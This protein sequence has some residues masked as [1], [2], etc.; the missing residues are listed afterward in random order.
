MATKQYAIAFSSEF[1]I[2]AVKELGEFM[3]IPINEV[4]LKNACLWE[5]RRNVFVSE[6]TKFYDQ[7]DPNNLIVIYC[8]KNDI[9]DELV[10][11][12]VDGQAERIKNKMLE[13]DTRIRTI[14]RQPLAYS[15]ND[16]TNDQMD[17]LQYYTKEYGIE[18]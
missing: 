17:G 13:I 8:S 9:L 14:A 6:I 2:D 1:T 12:C 18:F 4:K 10:V 3:S 15:I 7:K 16:L 11:R 5:S